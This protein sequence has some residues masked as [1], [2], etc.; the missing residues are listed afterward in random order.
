MSLTT[1]DVWRNVTVTP[2]TELNR[3]D[4]FRDRQPLSAA[5]EGIWLGQQLH[6]Q[7]PLYNTAECVEICGVLNPAA[8][9]RALRQ[10]V[11]EADTLHLRFDTANG[12]VIQSCD[13]T[14][15]WSLQTLNFSTNPQPEAAA[16]GWMERDLGHVIDLRSDKPFTQAL[17]RLA[18]ERHLWYQRIHHI[19]IDG[20]GTALLRRRVADIYT[21]LMCNKAIPPRTFG[22]LQMVIAD[23][24]AYRASEQFKRDRQ[25]WI[26]TLHDAPTPVCLSSRTALA[27]DRAYCQTS[28]L[29]A[30]IFAR[31]QGVARDGQAA[32]PDLLLATT[33]ID[34]HQT[35]GA[36]EV[37][38]GVP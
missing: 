4:E 9:E 34:L 14:L 3:N 38:L 21:A 11:N 22:S 27:S 7:H 32:W 20:Y 23:D 33:A 15:P 17:L 36:R 19:A 6:G 1:P 8:F 26:D 12:K 24:L 37:I 31:L 10:T 25:Y 28:E 13:R 16:W 18:P 30:E 5:Q 35:T 29:S 2:G